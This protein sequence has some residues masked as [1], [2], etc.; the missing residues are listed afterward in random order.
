MDMDI[1]EGLYSRQLYVLGREA[2]RSLQNS[3]LL[4]IGMD[5]IG[6]EIAKNAVLAGIKSVTIV[7]DFISS[8]KDM[9]SN[10]Y[11]TAESINKKET[12]AIAS[13]KC[14][15]ELNPYVKVSLAPFTYE[16]LLSN[17]SV[18]SGYFVIVMTIGTFENKCLINSYCRKNN[19]KFIASG[20]RGLFCW[21]FCDFG[22]KFVIHDKNGEEPIARIVASVTKENPGLVTVHDEAMHGLE[23]GDYVIFSEVIGMTQLNGT[24]PRPVKV[25]GPYTFE[26]ENTLTYDEYI[27]GGYVIQVKTPMNISFK[28]LAESLQNPGNFLL[29]D[30]AK[31]GRSEMLFVAFQALEKIQN[32]RDNLS[33]LQ[34]SMI[35]IAQK[36]KIDGYQGWF[37]DPVNV[38]ALRALINTPPNSVLSPI[39][40]FL[41]GVLGQEVIKACTGKFTPLHQW[42]FFDACEALIDGKGVL[43]EKQEAIPNNRYQDEIAIF[44]NEFVNSLH[45]TNL[46][47]VGAGAIGCEML[48]NW[49]LMGVSLDQF[50]GSIHITDMDKI[51]KSNLNRQFLFR[52]SD[53]GKF[54]SSAAASAAKKMNPEIKIQSYQ[55]KV[56]NETESV[57]GDSFFPKLGAVV[58]AL[59]NVE[60]RLYVDQRCVTYGIPLL[61]S[62]TLGTKG[63]TQAVIPFLTENYGASR[64]PPE[65]GIPIC[66]LKNF[67]HAIE[68]TLQWA[69]DWFEGAFTQNARD[70]NGYLSSQEQFLDQLAK[71]QNSRIETLE[72]IRNCLVTHRP[73]RFEE[74]I[75]WARLEFEDKFSNQIKQLLH[76]FPPGT[77]TSTGSLFW[78]GTKREPKPIEFN[79]QDETHMGFIIAA[80]N[81]HAFNYGLK[82][83]FD[84][85]A[86]LPTIL[87]VNVP[88]FSAKSGVKIAANDEEL[89]KQKKSAENDTSMMEDVDTTAKRI[90]KEL[91]DPS[92]LAG[93]RMVA[94]EFEKD[95]DTNYHMDFITSASNLRARNYGITEADKHKSK[96]IAGRIIP[97]IATT[98]ALVT[99]LV[100][101]EL[102]KIIGGK[103]TVD[104]YKNSFVNLALPLFAMSNPIEAK[105]TKAGTWSWTIWDKIVIDG[106]KK[107]LTLQEFI[108]YFEEKFGVEVQ[109]LSYGVVILYSMF[110]SSKAQRLKMQIPE[111]VESATKKPIPNEVTFLEFEI[112]CTDPNDDKDVELPGVTYK[113]R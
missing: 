69:R 48:K 46:F 99:G 93:Y 106:T 70:V 85:K 50:G 35:S 7:D 21:G 42:L 64:D 51:E 104:D 37:S 1:D 59:D 6:V 94:C 45:K 73:R 86:F 79:P 108:N 113:L 30:F 100:C 15:S 18:I 88:V 68:H 32:V 60:A 81:L 20:A 40:A 25:K 36:L 74:C 23:D 75:E 14:L 28:S 61:D 49:A 24:I 83:T 92:T 9:G 67:P 41:G 91:P 63:N 111:A 71:Q 43:S 112:C 2:Q 52:S 77:V 72:N 33:S 29:T 76:T 87:K 10:F 5:G 56:S 26:I 62:G 44:G 55:D 3:S 16:K 103:K 13:I 8:E 54:K 95:D 107:P 58:T 80:A 53:V 38:K 39:A 57:F 105:K 22:D 47:L 101:I 84:P 110:G 98:T 12:R 90:T 109:I 102:Y 96:F 66:T 89:E 27:R 82:G 17:P 31:L 78:S 97:A 4:V 34:E 11:I 19:S 65:K